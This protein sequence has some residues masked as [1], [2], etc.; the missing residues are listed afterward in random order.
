MLVVVVIAVSGTCRRIWTKSPYRLLV[1]CSTYSLSFSSCPGRDISWI[2]EPTIWMLN[3]LQALH[4]TVKQFWKC[5]T[6]KWI[7]DNGKWGLLLRIIF[8]PKNRCSLK[9][10]CWKQARCTLPTQLALKYLTKILFS[11]DSLSIFFFRNITC[12]VRMNLCP[13]WNLWLF[14]WKQSFIP[15]MHNPNNT[16]CIS[17]ICLT[18]FTCLGERHFMTGKRDYLL[19]IFFFPSRFS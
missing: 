19:L 10:S 5:Q 17:L 1:K 2:A 6:L 8:Q 9:C 18:S 11:Q 3:L 15:E 12:T 14:Y 4:G 7:K 13:Y 16:L